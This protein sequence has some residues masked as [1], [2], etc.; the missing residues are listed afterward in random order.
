MRRSLAPSQLGFFKRKTDE[1]EHGP[2]WRA[3]KAKRARKSPSPPPWLDSETGTPTSFDIWRQKCRAQ[4]ENRICG[5]LSQPFKI[6]IPGYDGPTLAGRGGLGVRKQA[7]RAPL[8]SPDAEDAVVLYTP[9]TL[10]A[11]EE[12]DPEIKKNHPV[13]VVVD[14]KLGRKL[15]PHQVSG[16]QF[17]YDC[18]TGSR[19]EGH[20]GCIMADDMGLGKTLQCITLVWTLLKQSPECK[21]TISK[22]IIV[23]PSSLVK[24]WQNEFTKWLG[25]KIRPLAIDGGTKAE[26]DRNLNYFMMSSG[27]RILNPVLI[28]SYETFRLH[29]YELRKHPVGLVIC[30]EGHR[31]KNSDSQTYKAL[32][33]LQCLRRIILSGTPIQNDLLEY[34]SL[35]QFCNPG[36]L[37]TVNEFRRKF[38]TPILRGRD[39]DAT[40]KEQEVGTQR[41]LEMGQLVN[42]CIIRRTNNILSKYL[43]PKVEQV[44]CCRLSPIQAEMYKLFVKSKSVR[45]ALAGA[46]GG[47]GRSSFSSLSAITTL[48]KLC[49][50]PGLIYEKAKY[51]EAGFEGVVEAFPSDFNPREFQ[52]ELSGKMLVLDTMLAMIRT[53]SDDKIVLVSNYTQ[54]LDL[55]EKMCRT[56]RYGYVRLDGTMSIKKRQKMVDRFNE[57]LGPDFV[58]MLSSKAGGCGLNLIGA[59]RLIMF[60]PDW[61][62]ANDEQA[63]ARVW[64]DGQTKRCY[65]YRLVSTGTIEEKIFQRQAHKKA[66]SSCV[67][68][69]EEDVE[70]HFSVNEMRDLFKLN[71]KTNSDTHDR[72]KCTACSKPN[73]KPVDHI[74]GI[75]GDLSQWDHY[76][77]P[78]L[79]KDRVLAESASDIVSFVFRAQSHEKHIPKA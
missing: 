30:D 43:P 3:A 8:H 63:M 55:F 75:L 25:D 68:D 10:T 1:E 31:L 65:I 26:I 32:Q 57:P 73:Y 44:V 29:V 7:V 58:F 60:D 20:S 67:V 71:E 51:R 11:A 28:I 24:N 76:P 47:G 74:N 15:R 54:T 33:E 35:V 13:H 16:V 19:I 37:G 49:N 38:E 12:S 23:A 2:R 48:K 4:H 34:F 22:A 64:R 39:A 17:L 62:P 70:R 18:V 66:L 50:H 72:F 41:L 21:P 14:P 6:P 78:S 46:S 69:E 52:P 77:D 40:D 27:R 9:P 79:L 53:T 5:I 36:M 56:R 61:N 45:Q 42:R 59:N